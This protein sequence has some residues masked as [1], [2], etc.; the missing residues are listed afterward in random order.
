MSRGGADAARAQ[1]SALDAELASRFDAGEPAHRL[2]RA[3]ADG[4]DALIL[5]AWA[6]CMP[7]GHGLS[8]FAV[9]GYGR[10]SL[11]PQSDV[12]LLIL[13]D[14]AAQADLREAIACFIAELW[15]AHV[16]VAHAVRSLAATGAAAASDITIQTALMDARWLA[17][18][19]HDAAR[20]RALID[21]D[22]PW[23][24]RDYFIAK[25]E[26]LRQ[27]H[28][29]FGDT[30]D[31]LE[32]NIKEGPGGLRDLQTLRWMGMRVYGVGGL[33]PL[34]A[35]GKIG[36]DERATLLAAAS[37]LQRLRWGLHLV[38]GKREERLRFD[39]QRLLA[40]RLYALDHADNADVER[41]MQGFY[42]SAALVLRIGERLLQRFEEQ[43]QG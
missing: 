20:L 16:E 31:N 26:E 9:G 24:P 4:V 1:L 7:A 28:A 10:R 13:G 14:E 12:D 29:R 22:L 18:D 6:R 21:A 36:H 23:T 38:A 37:Q 33:E 3:R 41:M 32:P 5:A 39:Y 17:G 40:A 43:L 30:A 34:Q 42:R 8:L 19:E 11:Y 15:D 25:R 27:R 2:A 35:M